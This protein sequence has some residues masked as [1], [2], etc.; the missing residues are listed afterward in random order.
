MI[1]YRVTITESQTLNKDLTKSQGRKTIFY[2]LTI[3]LKLMLKHDCNQF[4]K[5]SF[6][7]RKLQCIN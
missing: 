5:I 4:F 2:D 1:L 6:T 3:G 7:L